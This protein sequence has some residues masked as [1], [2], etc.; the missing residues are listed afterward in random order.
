MS[1]GRIY[2]GN[3]WIGYMSSTVQICKS[4][5]EAA[6]LCDQGAEQGPRACQGFPPSYHT[7]L[8]HTGVGS[9]ESHFLGAPEFSSVE[10][11][12]MS[13]VKFFSCFQGL[14]CGKH[15]RGSLKSCKGR[16]RRKDRYESIVG[17]TNST[18]LLHFC[19]PWTHQEHRKDVFL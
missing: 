17:R 8:G 9:L 15:G 12:V 2:F 16:K 18:D 19:L 6:G 3:N 14:A 13:G 1:G 5:L 11:G 7:R 10:L 4:H